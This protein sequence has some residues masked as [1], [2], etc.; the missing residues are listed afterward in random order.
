[1]FERHQEKMLF[2]DGLTQRHINVDARNSHSKGP[3]LFNGLGDDTETIDQYLARGLA[4]PRP[5]VG[6]GSSRQADRNSLIPLNSVDQSGSAVPFLTQPGPAFDSLFAG[7]EASSAPVERPF[8]PVL[9]DG[10]AAQI[11]EAQSQLR[12]SERDVLDGYLD[13]VRHLETQLVMRETFD[14]SCDPGSAPSGGDTRAQW[15]QLYDMAATALG[16][17]LT[18]TAWLCFGGGGNNN[19]FDMSPTQI[20]DIIG[21]AHW[22]HHIG[23]QSVPDSR[24]KQE[25]YHT[26]HSAQIARLMDR[27][28]AMPNGRGGTVMDDTVIVYMN[29]N[30]TFHHNTPSARHPVCV[31]G[32]AGGRIKAD[33]RFI[34]YAYHPD[35][36]AYT[37]RFMD[38]SDPDS[39]ASVQQLWNTLSH[40][41]GLPKDDW[42]IGPSSR[43][44]HRGVL[45]GILV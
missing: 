16:C 19:D 5:W 17:G 10:A 18:R 20:G 41:A 2:I 23:H 40:V 8:E 11:R 31:F 22:L 25:R 6:L 30:G 27:L 28:E 38:P 29:D 1:P 7:L 12:G 43:E 4:A 35:W 14:G 34:R 9:F 44:R 24:A 26:W 37:D 45:E 3:Q 33:G 32:S 13:S 21:D 36:W 15:Q 42:G 39:A